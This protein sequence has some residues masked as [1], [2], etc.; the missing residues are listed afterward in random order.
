MSLFSK[1]LV[2]GSPLGLMTSLDLQYQALVLYHGES[3]GY[4]ITFMALLHQWT[5]FLMFILILAL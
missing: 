4:S 1:I 3:L 5:Y 2:V